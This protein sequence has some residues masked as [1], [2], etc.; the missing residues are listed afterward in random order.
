MSRKTLIYIFMIIGTTLGG[1]VP[2]LW[3]DTFFSLTSVILT[4]I[5]GFL[6]IY[7]GFKISQNM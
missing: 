7:I 6:G 3:G 2:T 5:G 1:Y 4:A